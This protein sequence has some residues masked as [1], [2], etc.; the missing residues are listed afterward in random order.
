MCQYLW[1]QTSVFKC[2][3][4]V[5]TCR[6]SPTLGWS[7]ATRDHAGYYITVFA[8]RR[9]RLHTP[10]SNRP[11]EQRWP[12]PRPLTGWICREWN[13]PV[14]TFPQHSNLVLTSAR[15]D[16]QS[17]IP[18]WQ[19]RPVPDFHFGFP[20]A[21]GRVLHRPAQPE[22]ANPAP[23]GIHRGGESSKQ[24]AFR[25]GL[26]WSPRTGLAA[27]VATRLEKQFASGRLW[28]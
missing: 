2:R 21:P 1:A 19:A 22:T 10:G 17:P 6:R 15:G 13:A 11:G 23:T 18:F 4:K 24:C 7:L 12:M 8:D 28:L 27:L 26:P 20:Q 3:Q 25:C 5:R 16:V 14:I 9:A